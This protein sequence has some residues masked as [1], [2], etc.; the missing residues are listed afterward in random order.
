MFYDFCVTDNQKTVYK[1][2]IELSKSNLFI[3][4][5]ELDYLGVPRSEVSEILLYFEKKGL[6]SNVQ[7]LGSAYPMLFSLRPH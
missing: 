3:A 5:Q 1:A 6:F 7:H 2:L 4:I